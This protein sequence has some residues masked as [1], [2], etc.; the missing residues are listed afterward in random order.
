M[1][2]F[3][4][5][6]STNFIQDVCMSDYISFRFGNPRYSEN[7]W[8]YYANAEY[9]Y[10]FVHNL[11]PEIQFKLNRIALISAT[12]A[13]SKSKH[14]QQLFYRVWGR[15]Y[16]YHVPKIRCQTGFQK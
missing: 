12:I 16:I 10:G 7:F 8:V 15:R 6:G 9:F 4:I 5:F 1:H 2:C 11:S 13:E 14:N 3:N